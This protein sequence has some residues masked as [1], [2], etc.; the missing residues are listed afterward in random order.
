M[1]IPNKPSAIT[2]QMLLRAYAIG[3]FPMAEGRDDPNLHWI[4]PEF[5]GVLPLDS[6]H[7]PKRLRRILKQG[8]FEISFDRNFRKVLEECAAPASGREE[9][10]INRTIAD[11]CLELHAMGFAHSVEIW[12]EG[13][14]VGGLYG[15]ALGGAFFGES[16][17]S[18]RPNASK[19]ALVH[20]AEHLRDRGFSLLDAQ[21]ITK[22]L[23][24]FGAVEIPREAY[25]LLLE[26]ALEL[27]V[28]F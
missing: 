23:T 2:P 5:R 16:M 18:R 21:F 6:F 4:D 7:V 8:I 11:L 19:V 17:F 1:P 10:W 28:D 9:S 14:L 22:H 12:Q 20:L 3:V 24:Q 13:E 26:K 25:R 15:I 27:K